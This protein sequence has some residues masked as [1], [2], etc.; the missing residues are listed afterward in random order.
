MSI[1]E[2]LLLMLASAMFLEG[3]MLLFAPDVLKSYLSKIQ[4]LKVGQ[5]R[6]IGFFTFLLGI[7]LMLAINPLA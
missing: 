6:T 4:A 3:A 5:L 2:L 7:I 1:G